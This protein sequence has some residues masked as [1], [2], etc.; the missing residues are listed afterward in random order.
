MVVAVCA[1]SDLLLILLGVVG[2]GVLLDRAP[3]ALV[4]IRWA[5]AAFLLTYG[6]LAARRAVRGEQLEDVA[7]KP[8]RQQGAPYWGP[9]WPSRG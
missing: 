4:V 7:D 6:A 1:G 9:A 8:V 2:I 5:G 3:A